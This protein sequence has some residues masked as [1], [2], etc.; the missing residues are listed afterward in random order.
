MP[1]WYPSCVS[2]Y[3]DDSSSASR[4]LIRAL[5]AYIAVSKSQGG[6]LSVTGSARAV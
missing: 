5:D 6:D 2:Q 1:Y 4:G 3:R